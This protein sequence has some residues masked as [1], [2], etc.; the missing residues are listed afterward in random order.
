MKSNINQDRWMFSWLKV[1]RKKKINKY[2]PIIS[3]TYAFILFKEILN[4][5]ALLDPKWTEWK[6]KKEIQIKFVCLKYDVIK[7][8]RVFQI[9]IIF[10]TET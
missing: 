2:C 7:V 5:W 1:K 4:S 3:F 9:H 6:K 8:Y 10:L